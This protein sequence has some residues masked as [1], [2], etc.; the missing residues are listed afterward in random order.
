MSWLLFVQGRLMWTSSGM[1]TPQ[2]LPSPCLYGSPSSWSSTVEPR[3]SS[4][5][6]LKP[7]T[8]PRT[9]TTSTWTRWDHWFHESVTSNQ[10]CSLQLRP[11]VLTETDLLT[12]LS[13]LLRGPITSTERSCLWPASTPTSGWLPGGCPPS[14][15]GPACWLCTYAAWRT[16][17][18]CPTG[19]GTSSSTSAPQTTPSGERLG[20][21]QEEDGPPLVIDLTFFYCRQF[22][23]YDGVL[24]PEFLRLKS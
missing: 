6:S 22:D 19:R 9:T 7:S 8:T 11:P 15:A 3:V 10:V 4:S 2:M 16:F 1:R 24:G 23:L 20:Q 5:V 12:G 17:S 18:K 14:G 21:L 13:F